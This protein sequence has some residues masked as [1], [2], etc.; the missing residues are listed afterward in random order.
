VLFKDVIFG[1]S[2]VVYLVI[3]FELVISMTCYL[4]ML[5][6][7]VSNDSCPVIVSVH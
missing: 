3:V 5:L 7:T 2:G 1:V 6:S 4:G